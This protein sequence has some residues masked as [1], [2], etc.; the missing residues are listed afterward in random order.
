[1][2]LTR[3]P[4]GETYIYDIGVAVVEQHYLTDRRMRYLNLTGPR[5]GTSDTVDIDVKFI[6]PGVFLTSWQESDGLTVVHVEDFDAGTFHSHVT[7]PDSTF[8]RFTS[9]MTRK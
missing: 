6:R 7:M 4:V 2:S 5:A 9:R 1:V 3:F 8:R